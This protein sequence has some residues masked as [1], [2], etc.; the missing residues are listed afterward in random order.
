MLRAA[1]GLWELTPTT[2]GSRGE[3]MPGFY[4]QAGAARCTPWK[5][6]S[7]MPNRP[8]PGWSIGDRRLEGSMRSCS[9]ALLLLILSFTII[10]GGVAQAQTVT[11]NSVQVS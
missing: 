1:S 6:V 11:W 8:A 10:G 7:R 4:P 3:W 5:V 9:L 2:A